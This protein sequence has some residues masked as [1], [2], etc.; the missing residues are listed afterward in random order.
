MQKLYPIK[1][2]HVSASDAISHEAFWYVISTYVAYTPSFF[3]L[4][5]KRK[6]LHLKVFADPD[7]CA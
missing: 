7:C 4:M 2:V 6:H 3:K 5:A 1:M